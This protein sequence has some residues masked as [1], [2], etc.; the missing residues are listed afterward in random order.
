MGEGEGGGGGGMPTTQQRMPPRC[1]RLRV[2][3][4]N[5]TE[6]AAANSISAP[7]IIWYTLAVTLSSPMFI[8]TVAIRS[9]TV[10]MASRHTS[11]S[12]DVFSGAPSCRTKGRL[13][14]SSAETHVTARTQ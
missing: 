4:R 11:R 3:C 13:I 12:S 7:R 1:L 14:S 9:N 5:R 8:S 6:K 2:R 10:G